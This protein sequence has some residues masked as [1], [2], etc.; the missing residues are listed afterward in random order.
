MINFYRRNKVAIVL[1][2]GLVVCAVTVCARLIQ[3]DPKLA[4]DPALPQAYD[5]AIAVLGPEAKS[6]HCLNASARFISE[7][8]GPTEWC[9]VFYSVDGAYREVIISTTDKA[10]VR[11]QPRMTY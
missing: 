1:V 10:I 11:D 7:T 2:T 3:R 4:P 9:F 5:K 6:F 8:H